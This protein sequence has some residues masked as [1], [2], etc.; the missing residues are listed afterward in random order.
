MYVKSNPGDI[1]RRTA[2]GKTGPHKSTYTPHIVGCRDSL[3]FIKVVF[4]GGITAGYDENVDDAICTG[5]ATA[6]NEFVLPNEPAF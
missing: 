5:V 3:T 6:R 1:L 4:S 2:G